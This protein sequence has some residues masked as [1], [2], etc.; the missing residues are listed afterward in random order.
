MCLCMHV[1]INVFT[2]HIAIHDV[3]GL[4]PPATRMKVAGFEGQTHLFR[5]ETLQLLGRAS[6]E[7]M[8]L[9]SRFRV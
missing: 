9:G 7:V 2:I 8:D 1:L 5:N 3:L 4:L 6:P